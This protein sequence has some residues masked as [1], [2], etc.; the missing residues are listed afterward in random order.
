MYENLRPT[1]QRF[2]FVD[3]STCL[4]AFTLSYLGTFYGD[5]LRF[6]LRLMGHRF[7]SPPLRLFTPLCINKH[8]HFEKK[9]VLVVTLKSVRIVAGSAFPI[10]IAW[11]R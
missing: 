6:L 8:Q 9:T 3:R 5:L 7:L 10:P 2:F 11:E 1:A 4:N